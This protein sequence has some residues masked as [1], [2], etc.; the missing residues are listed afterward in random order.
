MRETDQ[1][2]QSNGTTSAADHGTFYTASAASKS[3]AIEVPQLHLPKGGGAIKGIDEKFSVNASNGSSSVSLPLPFTA[4]KGA[5]AISL[6][7]NSSSGNGVFGLGWS[8]A[9]PSIQRKTDK[10]LPRYADADESDVFMISG[11]EDLVPALKTDGTPDEFT[12]GNF[13]IKRYRPRIEGSFTRI[14]R[15]WPVGEN[16][17]YW[18][19]TAPGNAVTFFGSSE[20]SRIADPENPA[21]IFRWLPEIAFDDKGSLSH[22]VYKAETGDVAAA[23]LP[24]KNRYDST[25]N[26][27]FANLYLK[28]IS[29]GNAEPFYP[30]YVST[31]QDTESL[32][33]P[34]LSASPVFHYEAVFDYGEHGDLPAAGEP[35][36]AVFYEEQ[37]IWTRRSD[38][39]S[40]YRSG[41]D[42]RTQRICRRVLMFHRFS[43]LGDAP[44]LVKSLDLTYVGS[45]SDS[46][47]FA[48]VT[49]LESAAIRGYTRQLGETY[50]HSALP[51]AIYSYQGLNWQTAIQELS[52]ADSQN[53]PEGIGGAYQ[54]VD[55]FG[56]GIAGILSEQGNAY[57]YKSN[58]GDGHFTAAR[59]IAQKPC[60]TGL[61]NGTLSLQDLDADGS[62]QLVSRVPGAQGYF[63]YSDQNEWQNFTAFKQ[64]PNVSP[65]APNVL[66]ID[67]NGDGRPDLFVTEETVTRWYPSEGR[68]GYGFPKNAPKVSDEELGPQLIWND[69]VQRIFLADVSSDGL[70]DILRIRNGEIC[71]WPNL[72][73][74]R[75]GKKITMS[76]A[77]V[78]ARPDQFDPHYLHLADVTGTGATDLLYLDGFK[79]S[80]WL[81]YSGNSWSESV[82]IPLPDTVLPNRFATADLLG[83]GTTCI[84]WSSPLP[85]NSQAPLR[86]IDL[87]DGKKPHLLVATKNSMGLETTMAYKSS[88]YFYL[89]DKRAGKPW[90]TKLPFPVHCLWKTETRELVT[91]TVLVSEYSYHHGYFDHAEREFRGFGRVDQKDTETFEKW[92]RQDA[93]NLLDASFHQPVVLSRTWFHT[94]ALTDNWRSAG[95]VPG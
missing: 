22:Y 15:V 91:N 41:F 32:Y 82:E 84:V 26:A 77:P 67:L 4:A 13:R 89:Q 70:T 39:F 94:G 33:R 30:A 51:P 3:N 58:L 1:S 90:K 14:E 57:Y 63:D 34:L 65:S 49:Y 53:L 61:N 11:A 29:Y 5:P 55:F 85:G 76:N 16:T 38:A 72:G 48:E 79:A 69:P 54:W 27:L 93:S 37:Q 45:Q 62:R 19:V 9:V 24:D 25:G 75:F 31:P 40:E 68:S 83:Q 20:S 6:T 12:A 21:H 78:F 44:Y 71:Y 92:V 2:Q 28:R 18:K 50:Y 43:E 46:T 86:Y 59:A 56:E 8:A 17:F 73:Y 66:Q 7:Y 64:S 35:T 81:N 36:A 74:G 88:T 47:V 52:P 23:H 95:I 87:T 60:F 10:Q 80:V 42:I